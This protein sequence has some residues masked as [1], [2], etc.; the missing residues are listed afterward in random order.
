VDGEVV[1]GDYRRAARITVTGGRV[2]VGTASPADA[3]VLVPPAWLPSLIFGR[4]SLRELAEQ[5]Q[6]VQTG[7]ADHR[8]L[9]ER[10][11]PPGPSHPWGP[12][13]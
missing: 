10:M 3:T 8:R 13:G 11:L 4:R 5:S 7:P 2:E 6:D 12:S 1:L 9:V